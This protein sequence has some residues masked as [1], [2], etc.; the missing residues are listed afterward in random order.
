MAAPL[1]LIAIPVIAGLAAGGGAFANYVGAPP[2]P[3]VEIAKPAARPCDAQ[4][5]PYLESK[6]LSQSGNR[7]V[8]VVMAPRAEVADATEDAS[9]ATTLSRAAAAPDRATLPADLTSGSAVLY[10]RPVPAPNVKPSRK[11]PDRASRHSARL[12]QVPAESRPGSAGAM[13][14]VRPLRLDAFR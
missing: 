4:T 12:Y 10:Q 14:V 13:I 9:V 3:S 6:C 1:N 11:R 7:H 2:S 8:R 5:W